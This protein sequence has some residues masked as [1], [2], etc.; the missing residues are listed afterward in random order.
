M[1]TERLMKNLR[2]ILGAAVT[3]ST[4][5][6]GGSAFAEPPDNSSYKKIL[7]ALEQ[8]ASVRVVTNLEECTISASKQ[9]GPPI[10]SG[11]TINAFIAMPGKGIFF[12]DTHQTINPA[13]QADTEY[14]RY[15]VR[16]DDQ[17]AISDTIVTAGVAKSRPVLICNI[18]RGASFVW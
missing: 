10:R 6:V 17:L 11:Y 3:V 1:S 9:P 5:L 7:Q 13:G 8:G 12:A 15:Y 18:P 2:C 14:V 4:F 16:P